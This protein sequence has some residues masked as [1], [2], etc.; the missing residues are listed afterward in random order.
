VATD[1]A[2][3]G[4]ANTPT[5]RPD[6]FEALIKLAGLVAILL[7]AIGVAVRAIAF[8]LGG[9]DGPTQMASRQSV[10]ALASTGLSVT[11]LAGLVVVVVGLAIHTRLLPRRTQAP[12][13]VRR[14]SRRARWVAWVVILLVWGVSIFLTATPGSVVAL[15]G[16]GITGLLLGDESRRGYVHVYRLAALAAVFA[17]V[18]AVGAGVG[19]TSLDLQVGDYSFTSLVSAAPDGRYVELGQDGAITYLQSCRTGRIVGVNQS[20]IST[21]SPSS[22]G[23]TAPATLYELVFR[24]KPLRLGYSL[25]C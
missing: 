20:N 18:S 2:T 11:W 21:V 8:F 16:G 10:G 15:I 12:Q 24:G 14:L 7:P 6:T 19:G 13:Q 4:N 22:A 9:I 1:S 23:A 5:D 25:H 17:I 3:I